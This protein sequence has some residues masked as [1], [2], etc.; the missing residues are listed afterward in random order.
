MFG[1]LSGGHFNPSVSVGMAVGL[2]ITPLR[3][4]MY[5]IAQT[6]GAIVGAMLLKG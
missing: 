3:A 6:I 2:I 5:V 4:I 1:H